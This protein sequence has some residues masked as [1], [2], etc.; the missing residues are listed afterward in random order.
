MAERKNSAGRKP[1]D[2]VVIF[3]GAGVAGAL[4]SDDQVEFQL[5]NHFSFMPSK[6]RQKDKGA[7]GEEA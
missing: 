7:L 3:Q 2:E 1:W 5:H 4:Q 6:N